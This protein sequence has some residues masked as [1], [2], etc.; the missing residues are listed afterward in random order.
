MTEKPG[1]LYAVGVGPGDPEL[2]SVK[3]VN[4]LKRI[5]V[6]AV[7]SP[8]H[9]G[10]SMAL[11]IARDYI[12]PGTEVLMLA[13]A[14]VKDQSKRQEKRKAAAE[15]IARQLDSGKD[16]AFLSE[17]DVMLYSTFGYMLEILSSKYA[18]EIV[19]GISSVMASA[20]QVQIP[21]VQNHQHMAVIP[22]THTNLKDLSR[23]LDGFDTIVLLK[24]SQVIEMLVPIL[25]DNR[26]YEQAVVIENASLPE[27][28]I[29]TE[30]DQLKNGQLAYMSQ[31]IV[32]KNMNLDR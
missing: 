15:Q 2:L 26:L 3:A 16:V 30:F 27:S 5:S 14:M 17:G 1:K 32:S 24:I 8:A 31:M 11:E 19:P 25:K 22:A 7:P 4:V 20:A 6:V 21:L 18:I 29:I 28:R 23:V 10:K 12:Q 9:S 13:F